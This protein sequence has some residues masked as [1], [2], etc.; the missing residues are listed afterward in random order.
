M[1]VHV[2]REVRLDLKPRR[3]PGHPT[4]IFPCCSR[5]PL[6]SRAGRP[7]LLWR[8]GQR[9]RHRN[10]NP[11]KLDSNEVDA[12]FVCCTEV[13]MAPLVHCKLLRTSTALAGS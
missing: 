8:P 1:G 7:P 13:T 12:G 2:D 3:H 11:G 6:G 5:L 4:A 9:R 10:R